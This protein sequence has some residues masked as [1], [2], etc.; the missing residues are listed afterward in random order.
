MRQKLTY[1][2]TKR[3]CFMQKFKIIT[4]CFGL[5]IF[6]ISIAQDFSKIPDS[7]K[8]YNYIQLN[9]KITK[10]LEY[11]KTD[12]D[13]NYVYAKVCLL[14]GKKENN[15]EEIIYGYN[16]MGI[17]SNNFE[18]ELKYSDSAIS[19]ARTKMPAKLSY[20]YYRR[21]Q[22]FY[23]EKRLKDALNCFLTANI[24]SAN[25]S[26]DLKTRINYSIGLIKNT[27]GSYTEALPIYKKCEENARTHKFSN[28]LVYLFGLSELY[29]R[30]DKIYLSELYTNKGLKLART[31]LYGNSYNPYFI[32]NRGKN[33]YK[34][35]YYKKAIT[36]LTTPLKIMRSNNDY[37]NYAENS[38]YI[39]ECYRKLQQNE[40]AILYYKKVDSIFK[41]KKDIY[42]I[43]IKAYEY[44]IEYYK[45]KN[46]YNQIVY[47]SDQFIQADKVI[48]DNYK[49]ITAKI[50][51]NYDI[52]KVIFSKQSVIASLKDE[53]KT[54]L[55]TIFFLILGLILLGL[56]FYL[57]NRKKKKEFKKQKDLF[58]SYKIEREQKNI[59][60]IEKSEIKA[61]V[62]KKS[63]V[64]NIDKNV[65]SHIL[66]C[67]DQFEKEKWYIS[68]D[69]SVEMLATEFK[70]NSSYLSKVINEIKGCSF[71]NYINKLRIEFILEKLEKDKKFLNY[72][73][74]ALSEV[75]GYKSV[76]TFTRA[77]TAHTKMKPSNFIKELTV[78]SLC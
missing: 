12:G 66:S 21:G 55:A 61:E 26:I 74:Q 50:A 32:S 59:N 46:D 72:T 16:V 13:I 75:S 19:L 28:Y 11:H 51:K 25:I 37:S 58:E 62:I 48:D 41:E 57:N 29:N 63:T 35:N 52:Q 78:R 64:S 17:V 68:K 44:L 23:N 40:K 6:N 60:N 7:L 67:L 22:I 9:N 8:K 33:Y 77:F 3:F 71:T 20:T 47:Y 69:Y 56:V 10:N 49:Y 39:G 14:K 15:I 30:M 38:F 42:P 36:D 45:K 53:K 70:T 43:N 27:Q 5:F 73:I 34:R 24:D 1:T 54:S 4:L 18:L 2:S 76:Q 65:I 31:N